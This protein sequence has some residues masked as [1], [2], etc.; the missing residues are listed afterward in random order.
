M[1]G[2]NT[3][4]PI[5]ALTRAGY[6]VTLSYTP[7][8]GAGERTY[9]KGY[10]VCTAAIS[11]AIEWNSRASKPT[12]AVTFERQTDEL[13][14][15]AV[16]ERLAS[17]VTTLADMAAT[18][19]RNARAE[20]DK[21]LATEKVALARVVALTGKGVP[22]KIRIASREEWQAAGSNIIVLI[23]TIREVTDVGLHVGK[24]ACERGW[25]GGPMPSE[26]ATVLC[27]KLNDMYAKVDPSRPF[28]PFSVI[29]A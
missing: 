3:N 25:F 13:A 12:S 8:K 15:D 17:Y 4:N 21:L 7:Y 9:C 11:P 27:D 22:V 2:M 14:L 19:A 16:T 29:P 18:D 20:I 28:N 23:K 26:E 6:T 5:D 24:D 10:R 1:H